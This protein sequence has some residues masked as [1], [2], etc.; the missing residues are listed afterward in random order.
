MTR[1]IDKDGLAEAFVDEWIS[2]STIVKAHTSGSTGTP[3]E[4]YLQKKDMRLS[5]LATCR[6]FGID[7]TSV[8][9]LPLSTDYI[10]GKMMVVRA[11]VSGATLVVEQPSRCPLSELPAGIDRVDLT[12]VVPSQVE[13]LLSSPHIS[14]VR[15]VIIGGGVVSADIEKRLRTVPIE[16]WSTY[17]MTETCSHVALRNLQSQSLT[18][19]ALPGIRFSTDSRDCLVIDAPDYTFGRIVTN[20]MVRMVSANEFQ[21]LG[22]YDNVI[23]SGGIKLHPEAM[24]KLLEGTVSCRFYIVGRPS[25]RWGKEAVIVVENATDMQC[26]RIMRRAREVFERH[27]VPKAVINTPRFIYASNG[28]IKRVLP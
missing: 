22:R 13:G 16:A 17:G 8:L 19:T 27:S 28:K 26:D 23:N 4:M 6:H 24:E 12:A 21:W 20:D 11:F 15:S 3:K 1:I 9:H 5:A 18:Y 7:S 14:N 25:E 2:S 10:A